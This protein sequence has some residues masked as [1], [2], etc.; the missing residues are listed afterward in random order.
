MSM[1]GHIIAQKMPKYIGKAKTVLK[2]YNT[3]HILMAAMFKRCVA[4][5]GTSEIGN[6][7]EI[8]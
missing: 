5:C 6:C 8:Q 7:T 4:T 1:V 3:N 2:S